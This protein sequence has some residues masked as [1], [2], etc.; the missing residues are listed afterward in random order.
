MQNYT[1]AC[2]PESRFRRGHEDCPAL[3]HLIRLSRPDQQQKQKMKTELKL[4][5]TKFTNIDFLL[6]SGQLQRASSI[7]AAIQEQLGQ[8]YREIQLSKAQESGGPLIPT[9]VRSH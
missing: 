1:C 9:V 2:N 3:A 6:N 5:G 4:T 8:V 7:L